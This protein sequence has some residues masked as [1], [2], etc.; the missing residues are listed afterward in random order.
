VR[1]PL[2]EDAPLKRFPSPFCEHLPFCS[3]SEITLPSF[4]AFHRQLFWGVLEMGFWC[5]WLCVCRLLQGV[6]VEGGG[7][8]NTPRLSLSVF[9]SLSSLL[10]AL[11]L[12]DPVS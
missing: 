6:H 1:L 12:T 3:L 10:A 7:G 11:H 8:N 9:C 2:K 4:S 5:L